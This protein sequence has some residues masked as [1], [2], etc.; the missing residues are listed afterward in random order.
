MQQSTVK[1]ESL[2]PRVHLLSIALLLVV[3]FIV[4]F[5]SRGTFT[6]SSEQNTQESRF[7]DLDLAYLKARDASGDLSENEMQLVIHDMVRTKKWQ[8]ARA[9][10]AQRPDLKLDPKDQFLLD[11]ETASAGF[12][13]AENEAGSAS[14][15]AELISLMTNLFDNTCLL[16][17]SPSPRD[18]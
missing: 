1:R 12:Y 6:Y 18:S 10:M 4:L 11:I 15:K 2:I 3:A 17:T 13:G 5:P 9:L 14:Y 7:D 8:Q 16:Y